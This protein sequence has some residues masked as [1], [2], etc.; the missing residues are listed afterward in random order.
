MEIFV[1]M[2]NE[3]YPDIPMTL[4]VDSGF[5]LYCD[6]QWII[7]SKHH[8]TGPK[9]YNPKNDGCPFCWSYY[10]KTLNEAGYKRFIGGFVVESGTHSYKAEKFW[11]CLEF[12][13]KHDLEVYAIACAMVETKDDGIFIDYKTAHTDDYEKLR[14]Y[15]LCDMCGGEQGVFEPD[16]NST[17]FCMKC[18]WMDR[19]F[20]ERIEGH[21]PM[22]A[23]ACRRA[24]PE[25]KV[26]KAERRGL[27]QDMNKAYM[28]PCKGDGSQYETYE[29]HMRDIQYDV[30]DRMLRERAMRERRDI[31]S[32]A[33]DMRNEVDAARR[34]SSSLKKTIGDVDVHINPYGP[35]GNWDF[36]VE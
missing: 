23:A 1:N 7:P 14:A 9:R 28:K 4:K 34:R 33:I 13:E 30:V 15:Y 12:F 24:F 3:G 11:S 10:D 22:C 25:K 5:D 27:Y 18:L 19:S 32:V 35:R 31:W 36:T 29:D 21:W 16:M 20:R 2:R 6:W 26:V 8:L 17:S